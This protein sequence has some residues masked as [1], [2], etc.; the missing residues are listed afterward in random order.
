M[1]KRSKGA[2]HNRTIDLMLLGDISDIKRLI[3]FSGI[4]IVWKQSDWK[5][6]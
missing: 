6:F 3:W 1:Q 2:L 4:L 5:P